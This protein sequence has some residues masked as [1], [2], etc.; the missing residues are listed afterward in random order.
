[1]LNGIIWHLYMNANKT[2]LNRGYV[3]SSNVPDCYLWGFLLLTDVRK[4]NFIN[5]INFLN[6]V[7]G[8]FTSYVEKAVIDLHMGP[9]S[10]M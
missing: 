10:V 9:S 1:M 5:S 3:Y 6:C 4:K 7:S 8:G 2:K